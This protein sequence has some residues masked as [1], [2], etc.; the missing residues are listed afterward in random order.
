MDKSV[1]IDKRILIH[2]SFNQ[3]VKYFIESV[4][5]FNNSLL[6]QGTVVNEL[7]KLKS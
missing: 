3:I 6:G 4:M 1:K 7:V 2:K 5:K